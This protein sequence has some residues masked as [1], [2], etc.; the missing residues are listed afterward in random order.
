MGII[1]ALIVFEILI[2]IHEFGH[3]FTAK[4]FKVQV[5][6]FALGMGPKLFSFTKG[7]T[8]YSLRLLPIGGYC[9]MEGE[10]GS[11][12][13]NPRAF[14]VKPKWQRA[15]V[16]IAG[17]AMNIILG[18]LVMFGMTCAEPLTGTL[19]IAKFHENAVSN[20]KLQEND[21]I[22][23]INGDR[24][25]V[26]SDVTTQFITDEDYKFDFLVLRDGNEVLLE[27]VAFATQENEDGTTTM[28]VDF[29]FYGKDNALTHMFDAKG[30]GFWEHF[31]NIFVSLKNVTVEA[32]FNTISFMKLVWIS[33]IELFSGKY[34]LT[35]LSGP[36]GTTSVIS[37]AASMGIEPLLNIAVFI[38]INLGIM[39]LLPFPALDGG[40]VL[41]LIIEAIRRKPLSEKVEAAINTV[42]FVILMGLVF[43]VAISDITK[44]F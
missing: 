11:N 37:E 16:L 35:D 38:T 22:L 39:N 15:I 1:I 24:C 17:G 29:G 25:H 41:L 40:R 14:N 5:N 7:E 12:G 2:L 43:I 36:I 8:K 20:Q 13:E 34:G 30:A 3:F 31:G 44:L 21:I 32:F 26:T 19:Q 23:K 28:I 10:D 42:G 9:A 27:D 18:F 6:E 4:L 33:L